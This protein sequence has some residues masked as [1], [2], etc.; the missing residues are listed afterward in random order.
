MVS[1]HTSAYPPLIISICDVL[2][3]GPSGVGVNELRRQLIELNPNRFQS[4]VPR[5]FTFFFHRGSHWNKTFFLQ[6]QKDLQMH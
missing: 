5:M 4:A 1:P 6:M 3:L 2:C